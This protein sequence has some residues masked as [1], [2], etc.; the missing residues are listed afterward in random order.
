MLAAVL[1]LRLF[2][3]SGSG[4]I[5]WSDFA[6]SAV[7]TLAGYVVGF[8]LIAPR[9]RGAATAAAATSVIV[10]AALAVVAALVLFFS[11][12]AV[13][14]GGA[15]AYLGWST[16]VRGVGARRARVGAAL[17]AAAV[18]FNVAV[19]VA[20]TISSFHPGLPR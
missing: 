19:N 11:G 13:G 15:A 16:D 4:D 18:V 10:L 7:F 20:L 3:T 8:V 14:L 2:L 9:A 5:S 17:G 6:A 12:C 1:V